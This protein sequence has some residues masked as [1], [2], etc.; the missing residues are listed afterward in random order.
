[1]SARTVVVAIGA[2]VALF[3]LPV[4]SAAMVDEPRS[5]T[6]AVHLDDSRIGFHRFD[7]LPSGDGVEVISEARF[8]V[9]FLFFNAFQ[10]RHSNREAWNGRCLER[11]ES[12]TR[13][14]DR[15]FAVFGQRREDSFIIDTGEQA[16]T[17]DSC[18]MTFA[19]WNPAFLQQPR[20]LN[21]QSG[22]YLPVEVQPL[23]KQEV[24]VRG[25]KVVAAAY[26]VKAR[27]TELTVWY[28]DEN[29]W[30]G[31]ESVAKGG[32]IVRYELT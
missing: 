4:P 16:E 32:R 25:D 15:E 29:E 14:N 2:I 6:F 9:K 17:L 24:I 19:Y 8:D 22:E 27:N 11:I 21:P 23:G 13:E 12:E 3:A 1:V 10:Y 30:L 20:L 31:L 26:R 7:V 5:W 18:V 28:S